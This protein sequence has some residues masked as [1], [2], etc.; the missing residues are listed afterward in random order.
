M[1]LESGIKFLTENP[2][3]DCSELLVSP[4]PPSN[5][6]SCPVIDS[7]LFPPPGDKLRG[8]D[9]EPLMENSSFSLMLIRTP[10]T[11]GECEIGDNRCEDI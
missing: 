10:L 9:G 11:R 6:S 2:K 8:T 5:P 7:I 1:A 3:F 4:S